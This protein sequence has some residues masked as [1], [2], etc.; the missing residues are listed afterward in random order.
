MLLFR[1]E[2]K[3]SAFRCG[4][5]KDKN[6]IYKVVRRQKEVDRV[7]LKASSREALGK[8]SARHLRRN[9]H[10]PCILYRKGTSSNIQIPHKE[11]VTFI[12]NSMGEQVLVNIT[13]DDGS[14]K[15]A[16]VKDYQKDPLKGRLL[17]ADF[18]EVSLTEIVKVN[19]SIVLTGTSIGVK[20]DGGILQTGIRAVE[21][22]CLPDKIPAHIEVDISELVIGRALHVSDITV[23]EGVKIVTDKTAV[24][25]NV[26]ASAS[27]LS[28]AQE[29]Q[30]EG[31]EQEE[32][33]VIKK[34]KGEEE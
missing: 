22:E 34:G 12:N 17:H 7:T 13:F 32:P 14:S 6:Y 15:L 27:A 4:I 23:S 5:V 3:Q 1:I 33:E 8:G 24:L 29:E 25:A 21:V 19:V 9:G 2:V 18:Y 30:E 10:I 26:S 16:L 31:Q 11:I 20:R 28:D